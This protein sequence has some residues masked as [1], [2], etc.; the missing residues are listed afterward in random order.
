MLVTRLIAETGLEPLLEIAAKISRSR[1]LHEL[2][3]AVMDVLPGL[4]RC[5]AAAI[6]LLGRPELLGGDRVDAPH[7]L[8]AQIA[9]GYGPEPRTEIRLRGREGLVSAVIAS[10]QPLICNDVTLDPRYVRLREPTRSEIIAPVISEDEVVGVFDLESDEPNFYSEADLRVLCLLAAQVAVIVEKVTLLEQQAEKRRL[11]GQLGLARQVQL[12]LLPDRT[13][14][15][16]N[17]DVAAFNWA[18]Q[19]VS[20]DYYDFATAYRDQLQFVI[21][22]VSGKGLPS[23]LLMAFLRGSLRSAMHTGYAT[24]VALTKMNRLLWESTEPNQFVTAVHGVL[25]ATNRTVAFSNAGHNPPLLTGRDGTSRF[26]DSGGVPLGLFEDSRYYEYYMRV[27]PGEILTLY[28]DGVTEA[29]SPGGEE[30]GPERLARAVS[31][32]AGLGARDLVNG[33]YADILRHTEG[34]LPTDDVTLAVL[35]SLPVD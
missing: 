31:E 20:G 32:A 2:L 21:A 7:L 15:V 11:E 25:D 5:D 10:G 22:D 27:A 4:V 24:N 3:V 9:R 30:Y 8:R 35:K 34:R 1:D 14:R 28:T 33:V 29:V 6:Y 17:F 16:P 23:G 13:P 19:E 12:F 18:T 26:V